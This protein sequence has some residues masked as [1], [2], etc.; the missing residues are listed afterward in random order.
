M[1]WWVWVIVAVVA[2]AFGIWCRWLLMEL[3]VPWW[4]M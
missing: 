4:L 3:G 2:V 1:K